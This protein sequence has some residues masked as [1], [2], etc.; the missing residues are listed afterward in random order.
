MIIVHVSVSGARYNIRQ[1]NSVC[2]V[3][4][5]SG[6]SASVSGG[7]VSGGGVSGVRREWRWWWCG[8]CKAVPVYWCVTVYLHVPVT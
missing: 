1:L 5:L 8:W 3:K 4:G 7:G 2:I 6:L